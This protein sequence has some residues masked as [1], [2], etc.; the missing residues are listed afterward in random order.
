MMSVSLGPLAFPVGPLVI[1]C[2]I[3]TAVWLSRRLASTDQKDLAERTVWQAVLLS[4]IAARVVHIMLNWQ[5]YLDHPWSMI[6]IRDGGW[7]APAALAVGLGWMG[8]QLLRKPLPRRAVVTGVLV[9]ISI[10][11]VAKA[12]L[13]WTDS[14]A[15]RQSIPGVLVTNPLTDEIKPLD[16]IAR[17]KPTIVN[18]WA[19]WCGPCRIEMPLL[20]QSQAENPDVQFV[21]LNEAESAAKISQFLRK[22]QLQL[23]NVW[24]DIQRQFGMA[25]GSQGLPTTLFYDKTGQRVD[26]HFGI[27]SP[28]ALRIQVERLQKMSQ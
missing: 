19:T 23:D 24:I 3:W 14:Q 2:A 22:E 7:S 17:G 26:A 10:W 27:I 15:N 11:G 18:L 1:L 28:A 8:F 4:L 25:V 9:G 16:E 20:A 21:F 5:A 12:G 13:W 6:D